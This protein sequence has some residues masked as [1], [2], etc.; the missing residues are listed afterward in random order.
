MGGDYYISIA[1]ETFSAAQDGERYI[2]ATNQEGKK[3]VIQQKSQLE[4]K[5]KTIVK[6]LVILVLVYIWK[7]MISLTTLVTV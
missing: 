2:S 5:T 6:V 4:L 1:K 3:L 7:K